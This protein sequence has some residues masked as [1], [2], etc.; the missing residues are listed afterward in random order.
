MPQVDKPKRI[1][2]TV[3]VIDEVEEDGTPKLAS[4]LKVT[5]RIRRAINEARLSG[6]RIAEVNLEVES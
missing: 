5:T 6:A 4:A 2:V 3:I 1:H